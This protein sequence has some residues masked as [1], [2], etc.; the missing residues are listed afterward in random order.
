MLLIQDVHIVIGREELPLDDA[1]QTVL[2]AAC[3]RRPGHSVRRVLLGAARCRRGLRGG[4]ADGGRRRRR[5]RAAPGAPGDRRPRRQL[6][7]ARGEA[8]HAA[9]VAPRA[10]RLEP[11]RLGGL[12]AFALGEHPAA[13]FRLDS[14]TGRR[15]DR[16]CRRRGRVPGPQRTRERDR[17]DRRVLVTVPRRARRTRRV[18][19]QPGDLRRR[20]AC[21]VR[22]T[23]QALVRR[24]GA[25]RC[26]PHHAA[27]PQRHL[28][29]R[30]LRIHT[31][32]YTFL[33]SRNSASPRRLPC[34]P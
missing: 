22:G 18:R 32:R 20:A 14:F 19:A 25:T 28:V 26:A 27:A 10:R 33:I 11:A 29:A 6:A 21:G 4:H 24:A 15:C 23:H 12:E 7:R 2:G 9:L 3:R 1:Y 5:P 34:R 8:T 13:L 31:F 30:L 17:V 16:G